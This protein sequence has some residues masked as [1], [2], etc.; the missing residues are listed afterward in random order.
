MAKFL[1]L[2][3]KG[4]PII[5]LDYVS[6]VE[7]IEIEQVEEILETGHGLPSPK[8]NNYR[9]KFYLTKEANLGATFLFY[10]V[11]FKTKL[12]AHYFI[13]EVLDAELL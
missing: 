8:K 12:D 13:M 6:L 9:I 5:N 1:T 11:I 7:I 10:N 3:E 4:S 2:G